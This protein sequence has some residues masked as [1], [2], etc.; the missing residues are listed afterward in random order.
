MNS[1]QEMEKSLLNSEFDLTLLERGVDGCIN[2]NCQ[3]HKVPLT[4]DDSGRSGLVVFCWQGEEHIG[5]IA[6]HVLRL[7]TIPL[8]NPV[9]LDQNGR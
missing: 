1:R 4:I 5:L 7:N 9:L 3:W 2:T 6:Q 8:I